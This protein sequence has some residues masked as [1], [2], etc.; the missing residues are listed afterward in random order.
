MTHKFK[1]QKCTIYEY[2]IDGLQAEH[3]LNYEQLE[4]LDHDFY[5]HSIK[6]LKRRLKLIH[7][8]TSHKDSN[9]DS[10]ITER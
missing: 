3:T 10:S 5:E 9:H 7:K 6:E 8:A 1:L 4:Q 2:A